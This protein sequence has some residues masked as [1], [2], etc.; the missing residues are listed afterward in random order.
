MA[1]K[2]DIKV[3]IVDDEET[4]L[5]YMSKRL[6]RE[7]FTVKTTLSGEEGLEMATGELFDV[8]VVDMKM[9]GMDGVETQKA[10]KKVQPFLQ[11][12]VLTGHGNVDTALESGQ[13]EAFKYLLKPIDYDNLVETIREAYEKKVEVQSV[14]FK[15]RVEELSTIGLGAKGMRKA[16][17]KLRKEYG[18]E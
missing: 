15:E 14:K 3:L 17:D 13:Q 18:I 12:I 10:L 1:D 2:S 7:G 5:E 11:C 16:I 6:V 8:A 9:P 4:L